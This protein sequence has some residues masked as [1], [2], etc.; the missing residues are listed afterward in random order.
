MKVQM[1]WKRIFG[2][3]E[4][5]FDPHGIL[6]VSP[7]PVNVNKDRKEWGYK[8]LINGHEVEKGTGYEERDAQ[9]MAERFLATT[10]HQLDAL[11]LVIYA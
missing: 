4:A 10:A 8:V 3:I 2:G 1:D 9:L 6:S 7:T 5:T 11:H